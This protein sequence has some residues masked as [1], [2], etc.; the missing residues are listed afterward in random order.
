MAQGRFTVAVIGPLLDDHA[1]A[2]R[3]KLT[4]AGAVIVPGQGTTEEE[5]IASCAEADVI[6][7]FAMAPLTA[8]VFER[9]PK[10]IFL[11]QCMVGYDRID[12][13]A[14]T[15][16]GVLVANSPWF[17]I[18]EV[19]DHAALLILACARKLPH[20]LA[21]QG[22]HGWNRAAAVAATGPV[23]RLTGQTLG[24]VGFGTIARR[25]AEKLRGFQMR[26]LASDPFVAAEEIRPWSVELVALDELCRQ[27]DIVSMHAPLNRSTYHLLGETQFRAMKPTAYF[28]N[29]SRGA[30]VDEA[31]L[32]RALRE[33]WIAGAGLDVL[34]TEPPDPTNPLLGLPNVLLTPHTAGYSVDALADNR[35][36]TTDEVV[37]VLRGEWPRALINPEVKPRAR[38]QT[39]MSH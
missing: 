34:E 21:A 33:G 35:R 20:Q 30:T 32:I 6:L 37:R 9:L 28:V 36:Q 23:F 10:L 1:T 22:R 24:F 7:C 16:Y 8:R 17:C 11:Q 5:L 13:E 4:Q 38:L 12:V 14:A 27:T 18:E 25:T 31:A 26:Y 29:T 19:S 15:R 3:E 39:R 2:E